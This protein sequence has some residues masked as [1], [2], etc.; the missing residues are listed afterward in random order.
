MTV[1]YHHDFQ[2][3][4]LD[5]S[6]QRCGLLTA[7]EMHLIITPTLKTAANEKQRGHI[8]EL[9][10]QRMSKYVEP[11]YVSD[12][13]LRGENE[14][15]AARDLYSE[16]YSVVRQVGFVTNDRWGFTLGCSPDGLVGEDG[17]IE[18]KSRRQKYQAQTI[19]EG[20]L[21]L[22][23]SLQIQTALLVSERKWC[24]FI[25]YSG[26]MPMFVLRIEPDAAIQNAIV[27]AA[28]AF[29]ATLAEK[30]AI[31]ASQ[32]CRFIPTERKDY[33]DIIL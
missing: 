6:A 25:S 18:V 12:A 1:M 15:I 19:I 29:E 2:Q 4:S 8:Y 26:G 9:L 5:W 11:Q 27:E 28:T 21:P 30:L 32:A 20:V 22:E 13:M 31:Y 10:A 14:E 17:L 23:F 16:K 24:D 7:S 3:G 33:E